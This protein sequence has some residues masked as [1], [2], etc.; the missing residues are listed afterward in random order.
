VA[1]QHP[2]VTPE[3]DALAWATWST[4]LADAL[5][6]LADKASLT[7]TGP[8][9]SERP[10]RVRKARLGGFIPAKHEAVTPWVRLA[11]VEDF[12]RGYCVGAELIGAH[13]PM[14]RD[15][16]AALV[17]L[18]W[19]HPTPTDGEDYV[20]FWPDD[21]PLAP[22]LPRDEA[23]RAAAMVAATFREVLAPGAEGLP[24]LS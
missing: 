3:P 9:G 13:F 1:E 18:G 21:V 16:D 19:H 8:A 17:A 23:E 6:G 20:R 14:S 22:F 2:S 24:T 4:H 12:L 10:I 5:T 11:R 7:V 15:E